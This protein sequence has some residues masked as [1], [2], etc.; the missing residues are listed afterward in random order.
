MWLSAEIL[1]D[2]DQAEVLRPVCER[3]YV[4]RNVKKIQIIML[5]MTAFIFTCIHKTRL[6]CSHVL[7]L[8]LEYITL[9][10]GPLSRTSIQ[11]TSMEKTTR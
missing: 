4:S 5:K 1:L 3:T 6:V 2:R 10:A 8:R 7:L 11:S 9:R